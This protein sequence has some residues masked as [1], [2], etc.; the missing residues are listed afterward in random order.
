[1]A[2][3]SPPED[4]WTAISAVDDGL[5]EAVR[6]VRRRSP[7]WWRD[8]V[9]PGTSRADRVAALVARLAVLGQ[10]AEGREPPYPVP[11]RPAR[12]AALA[13]Q[14]AVVGRDLVAAV[15]AQADRERAREA[16][17]ELQ[18]CLDLVDPRS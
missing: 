10:E 11:A 4:L 6:R 3:E 15:T 13:D 14:L 5:T 9:A 18:E 17:R 7:A 8:P 1:M 16:S 2:G 12:E